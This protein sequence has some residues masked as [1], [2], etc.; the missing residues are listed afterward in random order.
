M[1]RT[2]IRAAKR[3]GRVER[4]D[5]T[6]SSAR[7]KRSS[8]TGGRGGADAGAGARAG[9][10]GS[11]GAGRA[12][13]AAPGRRRLGRLRGGARA[14]SGGR[15]RA[16][17]GGGRAGRRGARAHG[18]AQGRPGGQAARSSGR[19]R[20]IPT[21]PRRWRSTDRWR[22]ACSTTI[23]GRRAGA[24]RAGDDRRRAP[25]PARQAELHA[26]LGASALRRGEPRGS[27]AAAS[28][29][30]WRRRRD[31]RRR[32]R[33]WPIW[34]RSRARG[35]RSR[36]CCTTRPS[37]EGVPPQVA[38]QFHRRLADAAE[39]Q[40]RLD[41]AYQ[42][43]LEADRLTPGDLHTR[44]LLGENRYRAHRYREA[45]QYLAPSPIIPTPSGCRRR[46]PRPSITARWPS[47]SCGGPSRRCRCSRRRCASIRTREG[48]RP[49]GRTRA[50]GRRCRAR[51]RAARAAGGG[52]A[53][54]G[55]RALRFERV[56]DAILSELNDTERARPAYEQAVAAAGDTASL[57]LLDKPLNLQRA[58]GQHRSGGS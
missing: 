26:G 9:A 43:L 36:R 13:Q 28:A 38:A 33:G 1:L 20:R 16:G 52:D 18:A 12:G 25:S 22:A 44:L 5:C 31:I 51:A 45:A 40:G 48:A 37:R 50:R 14:R 17:A 34:R 41:D 39:Q 35:T 32:F 27:G 49:P 54:A 7:S 46:R 6:S 4:P 55:E 57:A 29:R 24:A 58:G 47:S 10:R 3:V 8:A 21:R 53:R 2:R 19:C 15:G 30:R 11:A 23:D 42:A 56:A